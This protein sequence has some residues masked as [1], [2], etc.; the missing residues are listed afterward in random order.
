MSARPYTAAAMRV[1]H[2]LSPRH[3]NLLV[4]IALMF[5]RRRPELPPARERALTLRYLTAAQRAAW[6]QM[7]AEERAHRR[8]W[9][10]NRNGSVK[11]TRE[12]AQ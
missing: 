10:K 11:K 1:L 9:L 12:R 5:R 6:K 4:R 7:Q 3:S 2:S 8:A